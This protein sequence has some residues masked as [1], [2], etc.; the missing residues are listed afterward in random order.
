MRNKF[1]N[2]KVI[3]NGDFKFERAIETGDRIFYRAFD[4]RVKIGTVMMLDRKM[5]V[6]DTYKEAYREFN[7]V[8]KSES[9]SWMS[10]KMKIYL[11]NKK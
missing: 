5:N 9:Y 8:I 7:A 1:N 2:K 4:E 3:D 10:P 11:E 6:L